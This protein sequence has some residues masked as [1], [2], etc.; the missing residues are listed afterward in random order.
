M[1]DDDREVLARALIL[2]LAA[3]HVQI[4]AVSLGHYVETSDPAALLDLL[5]VLRILC[6]LAEALLPGERSLHLVVLQA[7]VVPPVVAVAL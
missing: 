1:A 2:T 5:A 4:F 6:A 7:A 3:S